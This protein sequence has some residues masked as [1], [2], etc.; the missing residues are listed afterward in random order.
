[1]DNLGIQDPEQEF[2]RWMEERK[3]ILQMNQALRAKS[4]RG[5]DR[6]RAVAPDAEAVE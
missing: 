3:Q 4:T 6:E 5:G 2:G 1:M